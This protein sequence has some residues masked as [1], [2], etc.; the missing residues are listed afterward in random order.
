M[1]NID[2]WFEVEKIKLSDLNI[3]TPTG[4]DVWSKETLNKLIKNEKVCWNILLRKTF[5]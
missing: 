3:K 4:K 2:I 1:S 5:I